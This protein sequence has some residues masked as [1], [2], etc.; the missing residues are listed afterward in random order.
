MRH[1]PVAGATYFF[2][3]VTHV[4]RQ[5][6]CESAVCEALNSALQHVRREHPF[7]LDTPVLLPDH[8]HCIWTLP[9]DDADFFHALEADQEPDPARPDRV[10]RAHGARC[11]A[12]ARSVVGR[13]AP[14]IN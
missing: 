5:L 10:D 14:G 2:T 12:Q 9:T 8:L 3:V 4:R 1:A 11:V 7:S 13:L 6:L